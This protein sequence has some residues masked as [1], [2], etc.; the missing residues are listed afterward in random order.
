M[1]PALKT[2]TVQRQKKKKKKKGMLMQKQGR[3]TVSKLCDPELYS[4]R[5]SLSFWL[6]VYPLCI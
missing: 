6:F 4:P 2:F 5:L 3:V 1:T